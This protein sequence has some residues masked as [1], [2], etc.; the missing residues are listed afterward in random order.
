MCVRH[1][2]VGLML[3][4]TSCTASTGLLDCGSPPFYA[5]QYE[6]ANIYLFLHMLLQPFCIMIST[7]SSNPELRDEGPLLLT[8]WLEMVDLT[9]CVAQR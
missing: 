6:N 3:N 2:E 8:V 5:E 9:A 7:V 4:I 1:V